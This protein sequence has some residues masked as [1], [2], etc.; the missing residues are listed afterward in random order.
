M[1]PASGG[2]T[3]W[4]AEKFL[5]TPWTSAANGGEGTAVAGPSYFGHDLHVNCDERLHLNDHYAL[6]FA[7]SPGDV[8][9]A[10]APGAVLYAGWASGGWSTLGRVVVVD[11]GE[12]FWS[13]QAHLGSILVAVGD[14]VDANT[15][16]GRAGGSGNFRDGFWPVHLHQGLY[17]HAQLDRDHGGV[18]GGQSVQPRHVVHFGAGG[19]AYATI[20][21][22]QGL[23]F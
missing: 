11:L 17:R 22:R 3:D 12:G 10:P 19:G 2:C 21:D 8:V 23:S 14:R 13:L 9:L 7:L 5:Q 18:F 4:P 1:A 15:A 16:V 20:D 6:D